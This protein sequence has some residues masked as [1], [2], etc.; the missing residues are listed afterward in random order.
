M[1][2]F[3]SY[4]RDDSAD[5]SGR[6]YDRLVNSFGAK[7]IFKDVDDIPFGVNF[8]DYLNSIIEKSKVILVVIG[9]KWLNIQNDQGQ[10]R[11]DDPA[12]FVRIEIE[13]AL[14]RKII[15]IPLLVSRASMPEVAK[16]PSTIQ[17]LAFYNGTQIRP[18][19]DFH[20]DMDRLIYELGKQ[21]APDKMKRNRISFSRTYHDTGPKYKKIDDYS[22]SEIN[23]VVKKWL[24]FGTN[25]I[26]DFIRFFST[27]LGKSLVRLVIGASLGVLLYII[28]LS[29]DQDLFSPDT[30]SGA[31][32]LGLSWGITGFIAYPHKKT[33][34]YI[35]SSIFLVFI[36]SLPTLQFTSYYEFF[37]EDLLDAVRLST[38]SGFIFGAPVGA[39]ASRIQHNRHNI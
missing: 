24:D 23:G 20:K 32:M 27:S 10:R 13:A 33:T 35:F 30:E 29:V 11:L 16:L 8:S 37:I 18:D 38:F 26:R 15:I 9:P 31:A 4:R 6:I 36:I 39:I 19:P 2:I 34:F 17:E 3:I 5:V 25:K 1:N 14:K 7:A 21:I 28:L 12:D 22:L